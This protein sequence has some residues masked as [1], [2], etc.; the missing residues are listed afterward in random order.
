MGLLH[1]VDAVGRGV[2]RDCIPFSLEPH[3]VWRHRR[4]VAVRTVRAAA[5]ALPV[6]EGQ[7]SPLAAGYC[8]QRVLGIRGECLANHHPALGPHV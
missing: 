3:P 7:A 5:G 1:P 6:L 2:G 4:G 8:H